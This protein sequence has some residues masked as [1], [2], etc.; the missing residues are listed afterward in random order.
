MLVLFLFSL[1]TFAQSDSSSFSSPP[2]SEAVLPLLSKPAIA[3]LDSS[4]TIWGELLA[5]L[6]QDTTLLSDTAR[7]S[8]MSAAQS[9]DSVFK[10]SLLAARQRLSNP[11]LTS[12]T[13]QLA[14]EQARL[15]DTMLTFYDSLARAFH[16]L[17][18]TS[19]ARS[20]PNIDYKVLLENLLEKSTPT[21]R[22]SFSTAYQSRSVWRGIEQNS[23]KGVY[24]FSGL[25]Q[26]RSG[27]FLSA[28]VLG[29]QGQPHVIDQASA[30]IGI[31]YQ[32]FDNFLL[33]LAYTR[34][35]YSDSSVQV[36][37]TINSDLTL[38]LSLQT[39]W[40]TPSLTL[41][42]A[43]GESTN[44]FFCA[45]EISR[46]F[47]IGQFSSGRLVL[48]PSISAEYGTISTIRAVTRRTGR[49]SEPQT[50]IERSSPFVLTNYTFS[51]SLLYRIG[52]ISLA[53]EFLLA[54]PINVSSFTFTAI[55]SRNFSR[56]ITRTFE[57]GGKSFGY[58]SVQ[59]SYSL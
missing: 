21:H 43:I 1:P 40:L 12:S 11:F 29:L 28:S 17:R 34:Y 39:E 9:L 41:I 49:N 51:L 52:N 54:V 4:E 13:N 58:F 37:S 2:P 44:D 57:Q 35:H 32:P 30:S 8:F 55:G 33:S 5:S 19:S 56:P 22:F 53:P 3:F 48:L 50:R 36:R 27:I 38:W 25:Y 31:D 16:A 26:H 18:A 59:V 42:W 24:S 46:A 15:A 14:L 7:I 45:W 6:F 10:S 47:F 23:G 20:S